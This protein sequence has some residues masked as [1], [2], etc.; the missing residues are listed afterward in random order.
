M[1]SGFKGRYAPRKFG[2]RNQIFGS[3]SKGRVG[4]VP[5]KTIR[6]NGVKQKPGERAKGGGGQL[7]QTISKKTK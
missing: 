3:G 1:A 6:V 2:V 4:I 5:S 7:R